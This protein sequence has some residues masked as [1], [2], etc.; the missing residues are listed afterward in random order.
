MLHTSTA[1]SPRLLSADAG[2]ALS[3]HRARLVNPRPG[4]RLHADDSVDPVDSRAQGCCMP[5]LHLVLLLEGHLDLV[6]GRERVELK[7]C[8]DDSGRG[9]GQAQ[10]L[11]FYAQECDSFARYTRQ[12]R[13]ARRVS[14]HATPEWLAPLFPADGGALPGDLRRLLASHL[15]GCARVSSPRAVALAE[16][17]LRPPELLPPLQGIYQESRALELFGEAFKSL[18]TPC[19]CAS[20]VGNDSP[21][22][23]REYARM[24]ELREFLASEAAFHLSLDDIAGRIGLTV[25]TMQRQF[26]AAYGVSAFAFLRDS[27]M[28][29][30][31]QAL[32][33]E[34]VG[35]KQAAYLAGYTSPANFATAYKRRFSVTP[36]EARLA[37]SC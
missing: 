10:L 18:A 30:A 4:L 14:L 6:Y 11:L 1:L 29:R 32:E 25:N 3:D 35:I 2:M 28:L 27:R 19:A 34:G 26:R 33:H 24:R 8:T 21:L 22:S 31:R 17:L 16:Q 20:E 36:R 23:A 7:T 13:Y 12:G 5:G 15:G 37:C 9:G